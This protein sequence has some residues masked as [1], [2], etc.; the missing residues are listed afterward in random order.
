MAKTK[1]EKAAE[2]EAK[3]AEKAAEKAAKEAEVE[4]KKE[5]KNLGGKDSVVVSF[6]G[7]TREF[8]LAVH[9]DNFL[10]LAQQFADK[11]NGTIE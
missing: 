6:K 7:T 9:G 8:S 4:A 2:A 10:E 3:A 11:H 5:R 1:E